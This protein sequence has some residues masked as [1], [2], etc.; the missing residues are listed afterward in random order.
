MPK[1]TKVPAVGRTV[2]R[3]L[4]QRKQIVVDDGPTLDYNRR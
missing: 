2:I 1:T 4:F 3:P